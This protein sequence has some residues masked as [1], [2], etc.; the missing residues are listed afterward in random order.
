[1]ASRQLHSLIQHLRRTV[2]PRGEDA[3]GDAQLLE[4]WVRQRDEAAFEVLLWRH[5]PM[6]LS[7]CRRLLHDDADIDD[8]FQAAFLTLVR[9]AAS[10]RRREAL[11]AWLYRV[12]YR[13]AIRLRREAA[14]RARREQSAIEVLI[15]TDADEVGERDLRAVLDEE[16]DAL[17]ERYREAFV[18]CCLQGKTHAEAGRLLGRPTGT[19]SC[20]L[21]RGRERLCVR[22]ARRGFAPAVALG[23]SEARAVLSAALLQS[24]GRAAIMF[25][26]GRRGIAT[27]ISARVAGLV[28][29]AVCGMGATKFKWTLVLGVTLSMAAAGAGMWAYQQSDR[30][31]PAKQQDKS[32]S[33]QHPRKQE[34]SARSDRYGDPLPEGTIARLGTLRL[35][36]FWAEFG[37]SVDGKTIITVARGRQVKT[38]DAS[39]GAMLQQRELPVQPSDRAFLSPDGRLLAVREPDS[40]ASLDIWDVLAV[41]RL[42]RLRL[43]ERAGIYRA[44]FSPDGKMLAV[45]EEASAKKVVRIWDMASGADREFKGHARTPDKL[46]FSPDG[47]IFAASDGQRL[48]CWSLSKGEQLWEAKCAFNTSLAFSADSRT[49]IAS[50]GSRERAWHSWEASTGKPADLKLPQGYNY[51]EMAIAPDNRTLVFVQRRYVQGA[52]GFIRLWDLQ[53]GKMLRTLKGEGPIG[54]FFPDGKSFLT[55][56]GALQRW[57][58]ATGLPLLPET[59]KLGHR[60]EVSPV[61]Y[62]PDGL[63]LASTARD[64]TIRLWDVATAKPLRI[65]RCRDDTVD[66]AFSHDGLFLLSGAMGLQGELNIWN[67]ENGNEVRKIPLNDP[68]QKENREGVSRL[69]LS[70]DG[71]TILVFG[72]KSV[73]GTPEPQGVLSRWDLAT[74]QRKTRVEIG[75]SD[76]IYSGF[77]PDGRALANRG[78]LIDATTGKIQAKLAGPEPSAFK[79]Y[80]FSADGRLVAGLVTYTVIEGNRISTKLDGIQIWEAASGRAIQR[81]STNRVGQLAFSPD[82]RYLAAADLQGIRL[83]ELASMQVVLTHKAHEKDRGS[84]GDSFASSLA[85]APDGRSLATG[86]LD[87]TILIWNMV[88]SH[89]PSSSGDL[90]RLW[91]ELIASDAARAYAASWHL[92]ESGDGAIRFLRERLHPV[93]TASAEQVRPL[94]T[95]LDSDDFSKREAAATQLRDLGDRAAGLLNDTLKASPSLETRRRVEGLL[96]ALEGPASGETLRTLRA[97]TVLERIATVEAQQVLKSLSQGM[98]ESRVTREAK[99]SLQRLNARH[100]AEKR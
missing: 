64:G 20:W 76:A 75:P 15:S 19:I 99:A 67:T 88:P 31:P 1:M 46:A 95:N 52:D 81:I 17:P 53:T 56:D 87:S 80:V 62:S 18:L 44:S 73:R 29:A 85:F 4:R 100:R 93:A 42:H 21:K 5:G 59:E 77:S 32:Q 6:V 23:E 26:A 78:K 61:V 14:E 2:S 25:A 58:L 8:A 33:P 9:K 39:T 63:R 82:G 49:L 35:K 22:L 98:S 68:K 71:R 36:A 24:T 91:D 38:W 16:I 55:N 69:H 43:P 94:L 10:I 89:H 90:P 72:Y 45:A 48:I 83:W 13:I 54:P 96:K 11:A 51:A 40:L 97:M 79:P 3:L 65:L 70:A 34:Q 37:L 47:K 86:H 27:A 74:G 28:D 41:R 84:Y 57:E 30:Q 60:A 7:L 12:A 66:L 92:A 50:P